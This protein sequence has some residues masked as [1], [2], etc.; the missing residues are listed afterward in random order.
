MFEDHKA[1]KAVRKHEDAVAAWQTER[2]AQADLLNTANTRTGAGDETIMLKAGEAVFSKVTNTPLVE[3][4]KGAGHYQGHSRVSRSPSRNSG[5]GP[6]A[7]G[8]RSTRAITRGDT[9]SD[10]DR[11]G[12][13]LHHEPAVIFR[14]ASK[15]K[16]SP[17]PNSWGSS[18]TTTPA[19][20]RSRSRT[21]KNR[22]PCTMAEPRGLV[23]LSSRPRLWPIQRKVKS[24]SPAKGRTG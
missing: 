3:D 2:E 20:R 11:H 5:A 16:S 1:K 12:D 8:S 13:Y 7:I 18:T 9:D 19:P 6:S 21:A 24:S 17:S 10:R 14:P 4:R 15:P 23:R 22:P